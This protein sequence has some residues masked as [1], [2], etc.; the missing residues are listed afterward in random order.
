MADLNLRHASRHSGPTADEALLEGTAIERPDALRKTDPWRVLR[1]MGEFVEGFEKL[2]DVYDAVTMFGSARTSSEDPYYGKATETARLLAKAGFPIITG[3]GPGIMEAVNRGAVEGGGLSVGCNIEL[4]HEQGT[5]PFVRRSLFFRFF[6][7][8]KVMF[9]KYST[10]FVVFPGGFGTLDELFEALTL[11]QTGKVRQFPVVLMGEA[12]WGPLVAWI[13]QTMVGEGK[14][15]ATD[16]DL[17]TVTDN[18]A[19]AADVII[20]ACGTPGRPPA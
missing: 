1:I 5:N 4:P 3:G 19:V 15:D 7:V 11:I 18:P 13:R 12:Y 20:R 2:G 6:F 9:L 16:L 10:A 8:R 14:I 17:F